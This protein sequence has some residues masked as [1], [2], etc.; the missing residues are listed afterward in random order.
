MYND[1]FVS[2]LYKALEFAVKYHGDV[3]QVRK[4][5]HTP[6]IVHPIGVM[7]I[8]IDYTD[9]FEII[10]AGILHD[11]LEDTK[12]TIN[13]IEQTFGQRVKNLVIGATEPEHDNLSWEER[14]K[15]TINYIKNDADK[16]TL[17]VICADKLHNLN[18]IIDD[19]QKTGEAVWQR[20]NRG[21]D[22]QK[23]YYQNMADAFFKRDSQNK[24]FLKFYDTV[25]SFFN[26]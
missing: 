23:W 18:S 21:K 22:D 12:G 6:Y 5:T 10:Q 17:F 14:K 8:L 26:N 4:S 24:L 7:Q 2:E 19:Y 20:F 16:D 9:D 1:R 15:H 25:Q 11:I 13:D 3:L